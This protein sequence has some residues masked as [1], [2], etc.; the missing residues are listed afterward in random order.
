[1]KKNI[2]LLLF[3]LFGFLSVHCQSSAIVGKWVTEEGDAHI[4]IYQKSNKF[5]GKI[6]W[7]KVPS[8]NNGALKLDSKNP[9]PALR[10][11]P[12]LGLII[13]SDLAFDKGKWVNGKLYSVR[14][15]ATVNCKLSMENENE[16]IVL[17]TKTVFS[18][19][20]IWKRV[21]N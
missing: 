3:L 17:A 19:T 20:L 5:Y 6:V 18:Q 1:M 16:L 14:M 8:S 4:Q 21:K 13:L 11:K 12:I 9:D 2:S 10:T 7:L 15:G